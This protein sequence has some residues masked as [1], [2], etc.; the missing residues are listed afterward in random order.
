MPVSLNQ[1]HFRVRT[2]A[3]AA[4]GGTPVW[5]AA[6]DTNA[7]VHLSTNFRIRF[8]ISNTGG[9]TGGKILTLQASRNSGAYAQVTTSSTFIQAVDA[10]AGASA[11]QSVITTQLLTGVGTF[12][13]LGEYLSTATST[14]ETFFRRSQP[15]L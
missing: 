12:N 9:T 10:T 5:A 7:S 4:Q 14:T 11:N 3:T 15:L 2:D 8:S 6:Q 1:D 13:G